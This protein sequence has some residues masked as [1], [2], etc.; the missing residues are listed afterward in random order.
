MAVGEQVRR[1]SG[2][3]RRRTAG[4]EQGRA[5][6]GRG[7]RG[8]RGKSPP[9]FLTLLSNGEEA[10]LHD[11]ACC[12]GCG[13][14]PQ[15]GG[16]WEPAVIRSARSPGTGEDPKG[17]GGRELRLPQSPGRPCFMAAVRRRVRVNRPRVSRRRHSSNA[18]TVHSTT[19]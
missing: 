8:T 1:R 11:H 16:V 13:G 7:S 3:H 19:L 15:R 6:A 12:W 17:G 2:V 9:G 18:V 4:R 5:Y 10:P 14:E